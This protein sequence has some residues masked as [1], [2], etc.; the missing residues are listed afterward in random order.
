MVHEL[1][2]IFKKVQLT[3]LKQ[4]NCMW[5]YLIKLFFFC[6]KTLKKI[7]IFYNS[8]SRKKRGDK[9]R[10]TRGET[11]MATSLWSFHWHNLFRL[12]IAIFG[13]TC[14]TD[15]LC[16]FSSPSVIG[17]VAELSLLQLLCRSIMRATLYWCVIC[18]VCILDSIR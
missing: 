2:H 13:E 15:N 9:E 11:C 8:Q 10:Q 14:T 17:S 16:L 12:R 5:T 3:K 4:L 18:T 6:A 1:N 7:K